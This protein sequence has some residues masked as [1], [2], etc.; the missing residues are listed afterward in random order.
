MTNNE[1][2]ANITSLNAASQK[3]SHK[4][5][6]LRNYV[7]RNAEF[8]EFMFRIYEG[9]PVFPLYNSIHIFAF[10]NHYIT[11]DK[12]R[13]SIVHARTVKAS[14]SMV[15]HMQTALNWGANKERSDLLWT[16]VV[17]DEFPL[18]NFQ[19]FCDFFP[20]DAD[21]TPASGHRFTKLKKYCSSREGVDLNDSHLPHPKIVHYCNELTRDDFRKLMVGLM[22]EDDR[23][24]CLA[25]AATVQGVQRMFCFNN[26]CFRDMVICEIQEDRDSECTP[27]QVTKFL[28]VLVRN[29][30]CNVGGECFTFDTYCVPHDY[31]SVLMLSCIDT[32]VL[33][34]SVSF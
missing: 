18:R 25:Q 19:G 2:R 1:F 20:L 16:Y 28:V 7:F 30:K 21:L 9:G 34:S 27:L 32:K 11:R 4:P 31:L 29:G 3:E 5:N 6:T 10:L 15:T 33:S 17:T 22:Q 14:G 24:M 13:T 8:L 26:V 12:V 23:P